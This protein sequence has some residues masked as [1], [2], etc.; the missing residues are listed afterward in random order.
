VITSPPYLNAID[1]I[2]GHKFSLVWM[3]Y[4]IASLRKIRS[5]NIGSEK[6]FNLAKTKELLHTSEQM[7]NV[8]K[9]DRRHRNMV[10]RYI[11][12]MDCVFSECRRVLKKD[13]LAIFVIGDSTVQGFFIKNSEGLIHLAQKNGMK[14]ISKTTRPI[15]VT[16]R[17]LPPPD[18]IISGS[19]M[20]GRMKEEVILKFVAIPRD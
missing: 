3:G 4:T 8:R 15:P 18:W 10:L 16:R 11:S 12:D 1:Y 20:R 5:E 2:R 13:G 14:L 9:L 7:G 6:S 19:K 17:Y